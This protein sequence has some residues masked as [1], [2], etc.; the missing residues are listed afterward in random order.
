MSVCFFFVFF[1]FFF[2]F[3]FFNFFLVQSATRQSHSQV[4]LQ[5]SKVAVDQKEKCA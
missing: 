1:F 4:I 5:P 2:F 3:T